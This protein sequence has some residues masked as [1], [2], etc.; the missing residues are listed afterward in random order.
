MRWTQTGTTRV[1]PALYLCACL[2]DTS[3]IEGGRVVEAA[4]G[5]RGGAMAAFK[6]CTTVAANYRYTTDTTTAT[7]EIHNVPRLLKTTP[8]PP[9]NLVQ[10]VPRS[11][12]YSLFYRFLYQAEGTAIS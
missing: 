6:Q 10:N 1:G 7:T 3:A 8:R 11:F 2:L 9:K 12:I 4:A 5:L